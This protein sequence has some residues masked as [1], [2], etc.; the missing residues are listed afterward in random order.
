M[1]KGLIITLSIIFTLV[2]GFTITWAVINHNKLREAMNG[3]A[4]YTQEDL[5]NASEDA[6]N[7]AL[8]D[9]EQYESLINEYRDKITVNDM[10]IESLNEQVSNLTS[11]IEELEEI[12]ASNEYEIATLNQSIANLQNQLTYY[13]Q[14]LEAY[15]NVNKFTVV[16]EV[17]SVTYDIQLLDSGDSPIL[18]ITPVKDG[19]TF[20]GWML[21]GDLVDP[22]TIEITSDT[23][24][25]ALF[26][27]ELFDM[28]ITLRD[29]TI[30]TLQV[31]QNLT[32]DQI[33]VDNVSELA[34]M[35]VP[36]GVKEIGDAVFPS[37]PSLYQI[38]LPST[39]EKISPQ[40]LGNAE[41]LVEI[42]NK[43]NLDL[44]IED[45]STSTVLHEILEIVPETELINSNGNI[46]K[47]F[48]DEKYFI[49]NI[50]NA[51]EIVID[52][53]TKYIITYACANLKQITNVNIPES[54]TGIESSAFL[55]TSI[56]SVYIP[57]S[58]SILE[59]GAFRDVDIYT[60]YDSRP[61]NDWSSSLIRNNIMHWGYTYEQYLAEIQI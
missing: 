49:T 27:V 46:Y 30:E 18:P 14:L 7:Q 56:E 34:V 47:I 53:G 33:V 22:S 12:K 59:S 21:D 29:G 17:D 40:A 11:Q 45:M 35:N 55:N 25:S 58:V 36:E 44:N 60:G 48:N 13:E 1:K 23:T 3:T 20:E 24:F 10:T 39:L 52:S 5:E 37:V 61:S 19:Y 43:S 41:K 16:F 6:Y 2:L 54:I 26:E 31:T 28:Q 42:V 8:Q 57:T 4:I 50:N 15:Q 38:I 51:T 9:K 32:S